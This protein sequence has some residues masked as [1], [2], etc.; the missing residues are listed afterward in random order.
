MT[1]SPQQIINNL[2][3]NFYFGQTG[4]RVS[5]SDLLINRR[6]FPNF[7]YPD[8]YHLKIDVDAPEWQT[9]GTYKV[10]PYYDPDKQLTLWLECTRDEKIS[11]QLVIYNLDG[12]EQRFEIPLATGSQEMVVPM[13][14]TN[15]ERFIGVSIQVRGRGPLEIG[16]F[17]YRWTRNG[18]GN[19]IVGGK[20]IVNP[21]NNEEIAYYI[22]P[23][24]LKPPLFIYFSGA[25]SKEGFEAYPLF[26][27]TGKPFILFTDPRLQMGQFYTGHFFQQKIKE[28]IQQTVSRFGFTMQDVVTTGLSMGSYPALKLGAELGVHAVI[29]GKLLTN[30]GY[31][32][33]R[34]P[35]ERP[36]G[37]DT[38]LD[39]ASRNASSMSSTALK[40]LDQQFW[41]QF[42]QTDLSNT[43]LFVVYMKDDDYDNRAITRL[44]KSPSVIAGRQFVYRGLDGRHN[45]NTAASSGIFVNWINTM[46]QHDF[47]GDD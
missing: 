20:K 45:D 21:S 18:Y 29:C 46:I 23:G 26:K 35:R 22:C 30:L 13:G 44:K 34:A 33:E 11:V 27:H 42:D 40:K 28:I 14:V 41:Q 38:G 2:E 1:D 17:H 9:V 10:T 39:I 36:Y 8:G 37:F 3:K 6:Q 43:K 5:P 47:K 4:I 15:Y 32:A 19:Y 25:R 31:L 12:S 24:D 7:E 16:T